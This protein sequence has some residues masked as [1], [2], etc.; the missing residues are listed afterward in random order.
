MTRALV[1]GGG[2]VG[3]TTALALRRVGLDVTVVE[4]APEIRSTGTSLGLWRNALAV[5]SDLGIADRI[6]AVGRPAS[7]YFHDAAG[8]LL[9]T[10]EHGP[11]DHDY[12]LANRPLLNDVLADAV[13]R[14]HIRLSTRVAAYTETADSVTVHFSDGSADTFD[15]LVGADGLHSAVRTHLIPSAMPRPHPGHH[16]WRGLLPPGAADVTGAAMTVGH[17]RCR[18]GYARTHDGGA[19]WL[20]SQLGSPTPTAGAK[21]EALTRAEHLNDNGWNDQ[22]LTV[23]AATPDDQVLHNPIT[24]VP[25]LPRWTS[26]RVALAGDAAHAMSPHITAGASLGIQDAAALSH[27]LAAHPDM[28]QALAAYESDRIPH[29]ARVRTLS[30]AV[31][32][33]R[34]PAEFAHRYAAFTHWM[35]NST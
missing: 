29:Y 13:G 32:H 9:E 31:E 4:Q 21:S 34:T 8:R 6:R 27:H 18:G 1:A 17:H 14:A 7:M 15:L 24:I 30:D 28:P 22:L 35:I 25:P 26:H 23:I 11:A 3:L 12:F 20:V 16:T 33:Y 19:Y 10:P 2:I 5:F